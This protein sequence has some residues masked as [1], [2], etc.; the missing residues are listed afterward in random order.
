MQQYYSRIPCSPLRSFLS[1]PRLCYS[2]LTSSLCSALSCLI[3]LCPLMFPPIFSSPLLPYPLLFSPFLSCSFFSLLV[4]FPR[5][6]L[7]FFSL[8]YSILIYPDSF[9]I[10]ADTVNIIEYAY[11]QQSH[12]CLC[13]KIKK[14][15]RGAFVSVY[16]HS[17]SLAKK[18][19]DS[20]M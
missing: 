12:C 11:S 4:S 17:T 13:K 18:N 20:C 19:D 6:F 16:S 3:L 2:H 5:F 7:L 14:I 9:V 10:F 15:M 1:A 8:I